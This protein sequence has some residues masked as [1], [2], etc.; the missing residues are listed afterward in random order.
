MYIAI[1][2]ERGGWKTPSD[3]LVVKE[4]YLR[5]RTRRLPVFVFLQ[6]VERDSDANRFVNDIS[7]YVEGIFRVT[8]QTP[9]ELEVEVERALKS[10]V[11]L[12]RKPTMNKERLSISLQSPRAIQSQASLRFVLAPE[13]QEEVFDPVTLGN[14]DFVDK[15]YGI[16]HSSQVRLFSYQKSKEERIQADSLLV[17]QIDQYN[18]DDNTEEVWVQLMESGQVV[19]DT[20]VTRRVRRGDHY[21]IMDGLV[22]A[23]EDI[24]AV[25]MMTFRF[26]AALFD[27]IDP[28]KRHQRFL[29]NVVLTNVEQRKL[30]R[31]PQERS[32]YTLRMTPLNEPVIAFNEARIIDRPSLSNPEDEIN[33]VVT[34]FSRKLEE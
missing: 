7:D 11:S 26:V 15:V 32:S 2:G 34:L 9:T 17:H 14:R 27:D 29:Y 4:E 28:F 18:R 20:N 19:I 3:H 12:A 5:A 23:E 13:R 33:R 8:F 6:D 22:I 1:I 16:G 30:E 21:S 24:E 31:N 25:L 10:Q